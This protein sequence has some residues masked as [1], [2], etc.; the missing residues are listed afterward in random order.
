MKLRDKKEFAAETPYRVST[1]RKIV[2]GF[3]KA[4]A[5]W[6]KGW[7]QQMNAQD[8]E[9]D[10]IE[11]KD[12]RAVKF[13]W[14]GGMQKVGLGDYVDDFSAEANRYM[15][16]HNMVDFNDDLGRKRSEVIAATKKLKSLYQFALDQ[17]G[18]KHAV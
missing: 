18:K 2:N 6:K 17:K 14:A 7:C 12:K 16:I 3:D 1:L 11:V 8:A 15:G 13:C 4:I 10:E 5:L 9:G